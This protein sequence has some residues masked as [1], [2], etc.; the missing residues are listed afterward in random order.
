MVSQE[1]Y[2]TISREH[3]CTK[4]GA[5]A[6]LATLGGQEVYASCL[7][8]IGDA[9]LGQPAADHL[10]PRAAPQ[11]PWN[12]GIRKTNNPYKLYKM[13]GTCEVIVKRLK[14]MGPTRGVHD[15]GSCH[16]K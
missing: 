16:K 11:K 6:R 4:L 5:V 7:G 15:V 13:G 14:E 9:N 12:Q 10:V 1:A 3:Q 8:A 2:S